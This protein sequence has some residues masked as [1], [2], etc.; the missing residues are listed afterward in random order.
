MIYRHLAAQLYDITDTQINGRY[1][2]SL[3]YLLVG[4]SII[5]LYL[6]QSLPPHEYTTIT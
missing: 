2:V 1:N 5:Q 6:W 4:L 3:E